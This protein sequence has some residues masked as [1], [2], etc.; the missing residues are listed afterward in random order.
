[1][2]CHPA[3]SPRHL[4]EI[5]EA[6]RQ[7]L[8]ETGV[9]APVDLVVVTHAEAT[10]EQRAN[11]HLDLTV[12]ILKARESEIDSTYTPELIGRVL[13]R[14]YADLGVLLEYSDARGE[15]RERANTAHR[16]LGRALSSLSTAGI[17]LESDNEEQ[18]I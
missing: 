2:S 15:W 9:L 6:Q 12:T 8:S 3:G 5:A 18:D 4:A 14:A 17:E 16:E 11:R 10:P 1:M 13:A 7:R